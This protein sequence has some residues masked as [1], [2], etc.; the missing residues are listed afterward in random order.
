[1]AALDNG[2]RMNAIKAKIELEFKRA[3]QILEEAIL[4]PMGDQLATD[5]VVRVRWYET[6]RECHPVEDDSHE[7]STAIDSGFLR[8]LLMPRIQVGGLS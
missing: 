4:N 2:G 3:M 8:T 5:R 1:M 6:Y 7:T